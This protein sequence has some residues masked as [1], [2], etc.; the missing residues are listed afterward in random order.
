MLSSYITPQMRT[1]LGRV[2]GTYVSDPVSVRDIKQ[3]AIATYYPDAPPRLYWDE[4]YARQTRFGGIIAP[5]E[6][7]PFTWPLRHDP[8]PFDVYEAR[9]VPGGR[10]LLG[11]CSAEY[12]QRIRPGDVVRSVIRLVDLIE[13]QGRLGLMLFL[14]KEHRWSNQRDELVKVFRNT[15]II[16]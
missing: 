16:F 14:T 7:N 10:G 5:Q 15:S 1:S 6:F 8:L 11:G 9:P 12:H 13:R 4:A 2:I 3:W